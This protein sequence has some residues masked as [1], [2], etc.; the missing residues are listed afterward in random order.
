MWVSQWLDDIGLPQY[1]DVFHEAR[2]DP[3][4]V[5]VLT[6]DDLSFLKVNSLLH[7]LSIKR[8]IEVSSECCL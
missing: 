6:W 5:N 7:S 1:K 4:V 2:V 8:A 3:R